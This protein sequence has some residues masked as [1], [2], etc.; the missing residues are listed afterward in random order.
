MARS[1]VAPNVF[2]QNAGIH[3]I[4]RVKSEKVKSEK[5][6]SEELKVK[7]ILLFLKC[8]IYQ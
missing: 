8:P 7:R 3:R 1:C 5:V 6:K 2:L 4:L